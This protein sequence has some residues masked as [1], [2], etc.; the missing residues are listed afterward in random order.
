[1]EN[2]IKMT[3][4]KLGNSVSNIQ[5][6]ENVLSK[7]EHK[8]L[9]DYTVSVSGWLTQPWGVKVFESR[10]MPREMVDLLEK[11]FM[12]AHKKCTDSYSADLRLFTRNNLHL[13]KFEDGYKMNE[14]ADTTGDFAAIYYLNDDYAG[15]EISFTDH[16]FKIKPKANSLVTFPSNEDYWHEVLENIGKER[17]SSTLWFQFVGSNPIRPEG[18]ITR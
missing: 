11:V 13:I 12:L 2:G 15:G 8:K 4:S 10:K 14:H 18:G 5:V 7:E 3:T 17:Y 1:M 16:N 9:L 6:T